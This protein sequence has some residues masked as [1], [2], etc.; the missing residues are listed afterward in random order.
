MQEPLSFDVV[1]SDNRNYAYITDSKYPHSFEREIDVPEIDAI[2]K[3]FN[4]NQA[5]QHN[6]NLQIANDSKSYI[7]LLSKVQCGETYWHPD[8]L[9]ERLD[10]LL[11]VEA[12]LFKYIEYILD[13]TKF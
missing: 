12:E 5:Q 7:L 11:K 2:K 3:W 9:Q 1:I 13:P 8:T 6:V 10:A 4:H